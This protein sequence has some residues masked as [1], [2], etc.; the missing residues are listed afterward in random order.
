MFSVQYDFL[1]IIVMPI[2]KSYV[3]KKCLNLNIFIFMS[4]YCLIRIY[5]NNDI[6]LLHII[7]IL[8]VINFYA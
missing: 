6:L 7:T 1:N 5:I 2:E 4:H 8:I 3:G